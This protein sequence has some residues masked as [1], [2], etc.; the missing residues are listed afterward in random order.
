MYDACEGGFLPKTVVIVCVLW[1]SVSAH[2]SGH[3][4]VT[5]SCH[6]A[7]ARW[8]KRTGVVDAKPRRRQ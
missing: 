2:V 7:G 1:L 4:G 6:Q 8:F 5:H 3:V